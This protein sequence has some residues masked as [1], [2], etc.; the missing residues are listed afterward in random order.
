MRK[1]IAEGKMSRLV[2]MSGVESNGAPLV[3][4]AGGL[5]AH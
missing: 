4:F 3:I 2:E 1:N 5:A